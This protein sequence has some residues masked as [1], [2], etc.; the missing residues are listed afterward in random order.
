MRF[1]FAVV[2]AS[3]IY[4]LV[5]GGALLFGLDQV[6]QL[7]GTEAPRFPIN[8]NLNGLF[9]IAIGVGY[10]AVLRRPWEHRWYLWLMGPFLKGG[11]ALLFAVDFLWRDSPPVFLLFAAGDGVLAA[12]TVVALT[13]RAAATSD[14]RRSDSERA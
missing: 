7:L 8:A 5:L 10:F 2:L 14:P 1:L 6:R 13:G 9:A 4:D 11:G 12:A 3:G